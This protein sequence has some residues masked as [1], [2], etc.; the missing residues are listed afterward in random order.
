MFRAV[1]GCGAMPVLSIGRNPHRVAGADLAD[2]TTLGLLPPDAGIKKPGVAA[3]P[4]VD[5][6]LRAVLG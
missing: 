4:D 6:V 3:G 1:L 2:P 5:E